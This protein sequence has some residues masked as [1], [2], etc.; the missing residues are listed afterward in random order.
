MNN[1]G[2]YITRAYRMGGVQSTCRGLAQKPHKNRSFDKQR[3]WV[4]NVKMQDYVKWQTFVSL[5][6]EHLRS[7]TTFC[8]YAALFDEA[9]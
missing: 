4:D 6:I 9:N 2:Y 8:Y 5:F 1:L 3:R 7:S